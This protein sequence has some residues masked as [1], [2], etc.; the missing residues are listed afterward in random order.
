MSSALAHLVNV[1]N[2]AFPSENASVAEGR[3]RYSK[4]IF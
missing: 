3:K 4:E 1:Q 2:E